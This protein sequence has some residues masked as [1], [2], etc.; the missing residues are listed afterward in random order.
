MRTAKDRRTT[1]KKG[2]GKPCRKSPGETALILTRL[3]FNGSGIITLC[4]KAYP[5]RDTLHVSDCCYVRLHPLTGRFDL[6][7]S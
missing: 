7:A 1:G 3:T 2:P 6:L 4:K 5:V